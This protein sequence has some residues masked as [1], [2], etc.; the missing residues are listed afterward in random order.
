MTHPETKWQRSS[1][2]G[3]GGNNCVE[4]LASDEGIALRESENPE[5]I[6]IAD[7]AAFR[8]LVNGIKAGRVPY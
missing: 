8:S 5:Q 6:V 3:A 2:C 1:Y 4:I 7:L